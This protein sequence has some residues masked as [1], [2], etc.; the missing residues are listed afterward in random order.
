MAARA[1]NI[2]PGDSGEEAAAEVAV[3]IGIPSQ[4]CQ[5]ELS[6]RAPVA[7]LS[8]LPGLT[9]TRD[10]RLLK[11]CPTHCCRLARVQCSVRFAVSS[12]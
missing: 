1:S 8:W 10:G 9:V 12:P 4:V 5:P 3:P 2:A 7:A 11:V 6:H